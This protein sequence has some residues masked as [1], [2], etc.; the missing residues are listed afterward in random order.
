MGCNGYKG[1]KDDS[2]V[3]VKELK[4]LLERAQKK[5][6]LILKEKTENTNL[7]KEEIINCLNQKNIELA[8][9]KTTDLLTEENYITIYETLKPYLEIIKSNCSN[10]RLS[11]EC[12]PELRV[13]LDSLLYSAIRL[14]VEDLLI[15]REKVT[16]LYGSDF[17]TKV[18]KNQDKF[19]FP[20][21]EKRLK[22][23]V[24]SQEDVEA[25]INQICPE[26]PKAQKPDSKHNTD[27]KENP[28]EETN[29]FLHTQNIL[30]INNTNDKQIPYNVNPQPPIQ[31]GYTNS[32]SIYGNNKQKSINNGMFNEAL[33]GRALIPKI[34]E[35]ANENQLSKNN[36]NYNP[37]LENIPQTLAQTN[38][39][40]WNNINILNGETSET[41]LFSNNP[42]NNQHQLYENNQ[43]DLLRT[44]S[45]KTMNK[46][47][48]NPDD[49]Y[50]PFE[51][52]MNDL[53]INPN[54]Q[55]EKEEENLYTLKK[56]GESNLDDSNIIK[57]DPN[58][59]DPNEK[60]TDLVKIPTL[61][62][63][64][65]NIDPLNPNDPNVKITDLIK[66]PTLKI[67]DENIDPLN[68][69]DPN[70]K[71]TDLIKV[72]TLKI[73]DEKIDS[74]NQN[75]PNAKITDLIKVPTLKTEEEKI[76]S[77]NKN[78]AFN[79]YDDPNVKIK[80]PLNLPTIPIDEEEKDNS[81]NKK[82]VFNPYDPNTK[83]EDPLNVPT[84]PIDEE[85][86]DNSINK[87]KVFNPY[88]PNV[89]IEDP[90]NVPSIIIEEEKDNTNNK[91]EVFNPY[92]PNTNIED[93]LNIPTIPIDE[94][95]KDNS[96][97]KKKVYNPYDPNTKI[98]DPLNV[99]TI[100]IDEEEK[101][102]IINKKK[103]Y[104]PYD[105]NVIIEDP[106]NVP[107]IIMEEEKVDSIN[108]KEGNNP[109][110]SQAKIK[111]PPNVPTNAIEEEKKN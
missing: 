33:R 69:N 90:L 78:Q 10:I 100:P 18:D 27:I 82:K 109:H 47:M 39:T 66:V 95:E 16:K 65:E 81:I 88:D 61:K 51:G 85:E 64:D 40:N 63:E 35:N 48:A 4:T 83:I 110:Y 72:P 12:P 13:P 101:D 44:D 84:I 106:L 22:L 93:P 89:K 108:Q 73:E 46:S 103:V 2:P 17:I 8:N 96:I 49:K 11:K 70:A 9:A 24:F 7:K 19:V 71:I 74:L 98:E 56:K 79:P 41:N 107:S 67:E 87:K 43:N 75:D 55:I 30:Q 29:L 99:P 25:K 45:L 15:F 26:K 94:E 111:E 77:N 52:N 1:N 97:N 58:L 21:L 60:I 20:K 5:F 50:N 91:K 53:F 31:E 6:N 105:P 32:G 28:K 68:P 36:I 86:K 42:N 37:T 54:L 104:N 38:I 57:N 23:T 3:T 102:N 14:E 62:I 92:D 76:D 34:E 80:D 59:N